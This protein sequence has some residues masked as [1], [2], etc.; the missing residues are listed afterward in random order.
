[1]IDEL[2]NIRPLTATDI[3]DDDEMF[4][5]STALVHMGGPAVPQIEKRF[6]ATHSEPEKLVLLHILV[7]IKGK[8]WVASYLTQVEAKGTG[9]TSKT[10]LGELKIF[11]KSL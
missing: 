6:E 5:A 11:V 9:S 7:R 1:M 2:M 8:E 10:R 4:P 3:F